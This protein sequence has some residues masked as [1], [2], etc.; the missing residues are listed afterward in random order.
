MNMRR[1]LLLLAVVG[2]GSGAWGT[3]G[4]GSQMTERIPH[5]FQIS[6]ADPWV[7]KAMIEGS[8]IYSPELGTIAHLLG[9]TGAPSPLMGTANS[10]L[11]DGF[12]VV[13]PN[14]N[15]LWWYPKAARS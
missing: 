6:H 15:S 12:L 3:V 10:L 7:V 13:N 14:D 11:Q 9:G 5:R 4:K 1:V 8:A 2:V